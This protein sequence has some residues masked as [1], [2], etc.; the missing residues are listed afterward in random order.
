[1]FNNAS[2]VC[3]G[4]LFGPCFTILYS[5]LSSFAIFEE[6]RDGC[7]T[8][9]VFLMSCDCQYPVAFPCGCFGWSAMCDCSISRSHMRIF[10]ILF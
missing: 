1:M 6:E 3:G 10:R 4:S 2:I 8:L 5:I 9:K 7:F